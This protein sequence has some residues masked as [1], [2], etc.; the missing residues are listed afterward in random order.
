MANL[1]FKDG[2]CL[3]FEQ[4]DV[5]ESI[6]VTDLYFDYDSINVQYIIKGHVTRKMVTIPTSDITTYKNELDVAYTEATFKTILRANSLLK[7]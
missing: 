5:V 3:V 1:I 6:P 4:G 2:N 7:F